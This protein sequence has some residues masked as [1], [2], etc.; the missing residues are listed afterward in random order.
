MHLLS[1]LSHRL[2]L[3]LGRHAVADKSNEIRVA[4]PLLRGQVLE[5]R[6]FTMDANSWGFAWDAATGKEEPN[7]TK[8]D[9]KS[10]L[11]HGDPYAWAKRKII[12]TTGAAPLLSLLA[13]RN[14]RADSSSSG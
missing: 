11:D 10:G 9:Y 5:G 14:S 12:R 6:V 2:G 3:T 8:E 4:L 1:A 7:K 13:R